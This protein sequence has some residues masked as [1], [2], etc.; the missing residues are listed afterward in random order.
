M[1][2]TV[3]N[4]A[5]VFQGKQSSMKAFTTN[6]IV[7]K[8][9]SLWSVKSLMAHF[10]F[11]ASADRGDLFKKMFPDSEIVAKF[12]CGKTKMN[13]CALLWNHSLLERETVAESQ[14]S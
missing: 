8:A 14:R 5:K 13:Y 4:R 3:A 6:E 10:S 2:H 1:S 7:M 11:S 9:E 12:A